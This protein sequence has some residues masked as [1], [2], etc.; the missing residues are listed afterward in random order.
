[1]ENEN[2]KKQDGAKAKII[3]FVIG[4]LVG[5]IISTTTFFVYAKMSESN[6]AANSS[7]QMPG[8]EFPREMSGGRNGQGG[9]PPEMPN[10]NNETQD[11]SQWRQV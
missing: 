8:G 4:V 6:N 9:T 5:S 10:D 1:M 7:Q 3:L 11:N 2:N